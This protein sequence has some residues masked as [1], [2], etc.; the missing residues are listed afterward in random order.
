M[1]AVGEA[2]ILIPRC[3][4]SAPCNVRERA[5]ICALGWRPPYQAQPQSIVYRGRYSV[6]SQICVSDL[7][8]ALSNSH[9]RSV[10]ANHNRWLASSVHQKICTFLSRLE[11]VPPAKMG[12]W[13][14]YI[15]LDRLSGLLA[16]HLEKTSLRTRRRQP[17]AHTA[18]HVLFVCLLVIYHIESALCELSGIVDT[19]G[20]QKNHLYFTYYLSSCLTLVYSRPKNTQQG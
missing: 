12:V 15:T 11:Y 3:K 6:I 10:N 4:L 2:L 17:H 14:R 18:S 8:W 5:A 7:G 1:V 9:E 19:P 16:L 20:V 13:S